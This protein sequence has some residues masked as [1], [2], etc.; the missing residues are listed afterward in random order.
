MEEP[1]V[2]VVV[3]GSK[4]YGWNNMILYHKLVGQL[5]QMGLLKKIFLY[6]CI[7]FFYSLN[8][9]MYFSCIKWVFDQE[10]YKF[11]SSTLIVR[12][13]TM[14]SLSKRHPILKIF[15]RRLPH[16][17]NV[18]QS[19]FEHCKLPLCPFRRSMISSPAVYWFSLQAILITD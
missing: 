10:F 13:R 12:A 3:E 17:L 11:Q 19:R 4:V 18:R 1:P 9:N 7:F 2:Q 5:T 14:C 15:F 8:K 16:V 6:N